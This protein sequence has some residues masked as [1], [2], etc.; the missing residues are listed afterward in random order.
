MC[1]KLLF[2][3]LGIFLNEADEVIAVADLCPEVMR[4]VSLL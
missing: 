4:K 2:N 1:A 3:G